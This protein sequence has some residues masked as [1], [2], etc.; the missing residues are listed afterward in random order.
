MYMPH[1]FQTTR[2]RLTLRPTCNCSA[3]SFDRNR[4]H[5]PLFCHVSARLS[6]VSA[7]GRLPAFISD[8]GSDTSSIIYVR[9]QPAPLP[10]GAALA[11]VYTG[12]QWLL[13]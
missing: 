2:M 12:A 4:R 9:A 10:A 7:S 13:C 5:F 8:K 11:F 6:C 3:K 1:S